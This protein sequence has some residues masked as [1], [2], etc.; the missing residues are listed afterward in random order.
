MARI[1]NPYQSPYSHCDPVSRR[2]PA[3]RPQF[4]PLHQPPPKTI[5]SVRWTLL[6]RSTAESRAPIG[7]R[8]RWHRLADVPE[9]SS[10]RRVPAVSASHVPTI[11]GHNVRSRNW[12]IPGSDPQPQTRP[13]PTWTR[14]IAVEERL[15]LA[16]GVLSG[17]LDRRASR[18]RVSL[19][20]R[21]GHAAR[22]HS[23]IAPA[24]RSPHLLG[25]AL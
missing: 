8:R 16:A 5:A 14:C 20:R 10:N 7:P 13:A 2:A 21:H 23:N 22:L 6:R 11:S 19:A 12:R 3:A 4:T 15:L 18:P 9:G 1:T 17:Q 25:T 24:A